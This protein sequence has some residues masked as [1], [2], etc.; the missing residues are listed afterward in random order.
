[1]STMILIGLWHGITW[2]FAVGG[3]WHGAGLFI[4]N[5]WADLLKRRGIRLSPQGAGG[6][7]AAIGG[8]IL[9]FHFVTLGW[10]WFALPGL[11]LSW[12]LLLGLTGGRPCR[13][14]APR[15]PRPPPSAFASR[16]SASSS[17][18]T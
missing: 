2:N 4:H 8:T 16:P 3:A 1:M 7:L 11:D 6:R 10:A 12:R 18:P 15:P 17:W 9:T 14:T 5:R 13:Q